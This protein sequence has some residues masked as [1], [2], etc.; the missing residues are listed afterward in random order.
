MSGLLQEEHILEKETVHSLFFFSF[1]FMPDQELTC[2]DCGATFT[3]TEGEQEFYASKDLSAP[4]RC[5]ACRQARKSQRSGPREMHAAVCA[6]CGAAC[7][8]PFK[9][10]PVEEG[11]KPVLCQACF[12]ASRGA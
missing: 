10:R 2:R 3:F 12:A 6:Q 7:E 8:V 5:K 11:G 1:S 4:Q 9:P